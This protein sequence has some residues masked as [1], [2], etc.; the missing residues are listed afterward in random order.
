MFAAVA[1]QGPSLHVRVDPT[2][3]LAQDSPCGYAGP[4]LARTVRKHEEEQLIAVGA[5]AVSRP[6]WMRAG[7]WKTS[8]SASRR[9]VR[10]PRRPPEDQA[11]YPAQ[12]A[13]ITSTEAWRLNGM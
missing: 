2:E 5:A 9:A 13:G 7:S 12:P 6:W 4:M 8:L 1:G 3:V 10:S 11:V